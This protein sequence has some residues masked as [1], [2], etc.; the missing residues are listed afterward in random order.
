MTLSVAPIPTIDPSL[1]SSFLQMVFSASTIS[2]P[3]SMR[4]TTLF[5][6]RSYFIQDAATMRRI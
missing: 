5:P 4:T 6:N 2:S 3:L 1:I